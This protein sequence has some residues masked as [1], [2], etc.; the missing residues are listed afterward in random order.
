MII[1][2]T[3]QNGNW[4]PDNL[5]LWERLSR[6]YSGIRMTMD[7]KPFKKKRTLKENNYYWGV[8]IKHISDF[9]GMTPE[10]AHDSMRWKFLRKIEKGIETVESTTDLTTDR[11]EW[12]YMQ[13]RIFFNSEFG[14]MIP[15]PN[16]VL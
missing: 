1:D 15:L 11:A 2:G 16:E 8:I 6:S 7:I 14:V 10:E 13:I 3:F 9:T 12:Y 4:M 5:P